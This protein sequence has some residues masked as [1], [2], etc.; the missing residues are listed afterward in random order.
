MISHVSL[1]AR[2]LPRSTRFFDA[3]LSAL[4]YAHLYASEKVSGYGSPGDA[5]AKLDVFAIAPDEPARAPRGFHVAFEAETPAAV[6]AFHAAALAAGGSDA[7]GPGLR[8]Q[9]GEGYF[10]AFV[11]DPD[12]HKIEA[13]HQPARR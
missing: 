3:C 1:G 11:L 5:A 10:A 2:D 9:Y 13:V 12:G 8:P 7:G 6:R 4:G